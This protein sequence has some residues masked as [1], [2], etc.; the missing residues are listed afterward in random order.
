MGYARALKTSLLGTALPYGFALTVFTSGQALLHLHGSPNVG[1]L[2]LFAAGVAAA[3]GSL[4]LFT[5]GT[6]TAGSSPSKT[7]HPVRAGSVHVAAI[8]L[9]LGTAALLGQIPGG[10]AW[11]LAG[12]CSTLVYL[13]VNALEPLAQAK[14]DAG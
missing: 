4:R 12:L 10:V 3:Y 2:Y 8:G 13:L 14:R 6:P 7:D 5:W 1:Q 9:G 11:P